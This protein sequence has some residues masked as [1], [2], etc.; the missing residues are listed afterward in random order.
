MCAASKL[1]SLPVS[2]ACSLRS[3]VTIWSYLK[4]DPARSLIGTKLPPYRKTNARGISFRVGYSYSSERSERGTRKGVSQSN[5]LA[6]RDI[7]IFEPARGTAS[8]YRIAY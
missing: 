3:L 4:T 1:L 6:H 2:T 7:E 5:G 8:I